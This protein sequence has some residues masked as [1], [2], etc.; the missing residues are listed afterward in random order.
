MKQIVLKLVILLL[1]SSCGK[2]KD[3]KASFSVDIL[4]TVDSTYNFSFQNNSENAVNYEWDFGDGSTSSQTNPKH[5]Y[6]KKG[7]FEVQLTVTNEKG[8]FESS[9]QKIIIGD[10]YLASFEADISGLNWS[11][12][13]HYADCNN[14]NTTIDGNFLEY[15]IDGG[16]RLESRPNTSTDFLS[17]Q[18]DYDNR[19]LFID[20]NLLNAIATEVP[21]RLTFYYEIYSP[22]TAFGN[23]NCRV[24][25]TSV[26]PSQSTLSPLAYSALLLQEENQPFEI[27]HE[28]WDDDREVMFKGISK[29][30]IQFF[31]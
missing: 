18:F 24:R 15:R 19:D 14:N 17:Y 26:Y 3:P 22:G 25:F 27:E 29:L 7:V 6:G 31:E 12:V 5:I 11:L 20:R 4:Q 8:D 2:H 1:L 9:S 23:P 30:G 10:W 21:Y 16:G 28:F 13:E